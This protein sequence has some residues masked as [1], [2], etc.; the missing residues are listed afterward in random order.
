MYFFLYILFRLIVF[1][2]W[3][4]KCFSFCQKLLSRPGFEPG[5]LRP[6]RNVLTTRRSGPI[7]LQGNRFH[8]FSRF[9]GFWRF[10]TLSRQTFV[11]FCFANLISVY[12]SSA[13]ISR[14]LSFS[15]IIN[16]GFLAS[17]DFL[18]NFF[19]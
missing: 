5:L 15:L 11:D 9:R 4:I 1:G 6:Q 14:F 7:L 19:D 8:I 12:F 3:F 13:N 10:G 16:Q 17:D 18:N 2:M